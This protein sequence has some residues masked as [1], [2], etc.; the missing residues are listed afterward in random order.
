MNKNYLLNK[1]LFFDIEYVNY[2][3]ELIQINEFCSFDGLNYNNF[4]S[5]E[6]FQRETSKNITIKNPHT[7]CSQEE[8]KKKIGE[9]INY[10]SKHRIFI[11]FGISSDLD[12]LKKWGINK[13]LNNPKG[14]D[15]LKFVCARNLCRTIIYS[16]DYFNFCVKNS[17]ITNNGKVKSK[18]II[19]YYYVFRERFKTHTSYNDVTALAR[20]INEIS[21]G[22]N[23]I[24]KSLNKRDM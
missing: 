20:L 18:L 11:A 21:I 17:Y 10:Y 19:I 3:N 13:Y 24:Y 16:K 4:I 14:L 22:K 8:L 15:S 9:I 1:A 5:E 12:I 23:L 6:R 7:V 2:K